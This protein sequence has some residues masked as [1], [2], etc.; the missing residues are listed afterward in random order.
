VVY[1]LVSLADITTVL[2]LLNGMAMG[3]KVGEKSTSALVYEYIQGS[4]KVIM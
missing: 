1:T 3:T 2:E 4:N